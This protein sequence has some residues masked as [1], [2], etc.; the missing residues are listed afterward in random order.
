MKKRISGI[1][2]IAAAALLSGSMLFAASD[3]IS[4]EKAMEIA[5]ADAGTAESSVRFVRSDLDRDDGRMIYDVEFYDDGTEYD[6][7]IDAY[8]G[9][10]LSK[11][12]DAEYWN[13]RGSR[14]GSVD[15]DTALEIALA[16]AAVSDP[17]RVKVKLDRDDGRLQYEV[18]FCTADGEYEYVIDADNGRIIE[19]GMDRWNDQGRPHHT[20]HHDRAAYSENDALAAVLERV[21]GAEASDVWMH[22]DRDD[23]RDIYEGEVRF[24]GYEYEFEIDAATG[25]FIDWDR[26]RY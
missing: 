10:I 15:D 7:E 25:R 6:Y 12:R 18:E 2:V 11:D 22:M 14:E 24:D 8:T 21:P 20:R 4:R 9:D 23:G 1:I 26:D 13:G 19:A 16:D 17:E 3:Y 5:L